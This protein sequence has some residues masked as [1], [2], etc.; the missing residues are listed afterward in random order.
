MHGMINRGLQNFVSA[1]FGQHSWEEACTMAGLP[2]SQ[3][4]AMLSYDDL[5]TEQVLDAMVE[6]TGRERPI[7]LEDFGTFIVSE[8]SSPAVRR[9]LRL[10]G[11]NFTE[12]LFSLEDV[13]DRVSLAL[14][15]LELPM[16]QV[17]TVGMNKF[18]V[19]SLF[20]KFG[21]GE[22]FLGLLRAMADD[23][24]TL[25]FIE[26]QKIGTDGVAEDWYRIDILD[27][28]WTKDKPS[29]AEVLQ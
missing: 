1:I 11:E 3:F 25:V 12:F 8:H 22:V 23:Y 10:G 17:E 24:E 21:Y 18:I 5:L 7:L 6:T 27:A 13:N 14:P 20:N 16:L 2:F 4:E 29:K 9:L 26:H 28:A 19:K 15:D